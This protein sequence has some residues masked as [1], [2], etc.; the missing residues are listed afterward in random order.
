[1]SNEKTISKNKKGLSF[2]LL[3][4]A[5]I[6]VI[7]CISA[8]GLATWAR[9]TSALNGNGVQANIASWSFKVNGSSTEI[10][11][12]DLGQTSFNNVSR[13][14][15]APG[16][17]GAFTLNL[18]ATGTDV[19]LDYYIDMVLSKKPTNLNFY[20]NESHSELLVF[21]SADKSVRVT[22]EISATATDKTVS[23]TIYWDWPYQT[24]T[25]PDS[26]LITDY[27]LS[28]YESKYNAEGTSGAQTDKQ[29]EIA[30]IMNDIID[31]AEAGSKVEATLTVT[32]I[33][34][35]PTP[36]VTPTQE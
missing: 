7:M 36:V 30:G 28:S 17:S 14:Y 4:I 20:T 31:T 25:L 27:S 23:K 33:Q 19:S 11:T 18:D 32:G 12:I 6:A 8:F 5:L 15:I 13:G 1:M 16:T 2:M 26:S 24:T 34:K 9:F 21:S 22:G 10:A 3:V 29:K 35:A